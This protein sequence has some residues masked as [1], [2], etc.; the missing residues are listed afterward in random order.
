[1]D[2]SRF[3]SLISTHR[4]IRLKQKKRYWQNLHEIRFFVNDDFTIY[5][6]ILKFLI[7]LFIEMI[8]FI[9]GINLQNQKLG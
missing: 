2:F 4:P 1:M 9:K 8:S 6:F 3:P 5:L 7:V